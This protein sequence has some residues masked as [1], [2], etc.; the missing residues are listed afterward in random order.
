MQRHFA[1][2][3]AGNAVLK[4]VYQRTRTAPSDRRCTRSLA[5]VQVLVLYHLVTA[6]ATA[7]QQ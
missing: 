2:L 6:R 5:I 4:P 3:R 1:E 7:C